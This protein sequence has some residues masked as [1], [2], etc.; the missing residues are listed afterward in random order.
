MPGAGCPGMHSETDQHSNLDVS[1]FRR[2]VSRLLGPE[3]DPR[4]RSCNLRVSW[5]FKVNY[6]AN[7]LVLLYSHC[8]L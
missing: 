3:D 6:V 2:T 5:R 8:L 7:I 1:G 4:W